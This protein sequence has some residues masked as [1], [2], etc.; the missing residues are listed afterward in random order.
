MKQF[1]CNRAFDK[2]E[3]KRLIYWFLTNYETSKTLQMID[4]LKTVGFH[5]ATK[6]GISLGIED[7]KIPPIKKRLLKNAEDEIQKNDYR[8]S[9]GKLTAVERS[10]K[11][12]DV[13]N[14]TS[15]LLKEE[16]IYHFRQTDLLNPVY[17][18]AFS[19]ARG[20][21]S[22][23]RQLVGMRGLMSDPQGEII[24]L[25]IKSNFREGLTVTEYI[26]SC[27]GARKGLVDTA[28]KTANSGYLTRRLVDVAQAVIINEVDCNAPSGIYLTSLLEKSKVLLPLEK[29]LVGRVLAQDIRNE[30]TG[31][32]IAKKNQDI[33]PQLAKRILK[34]GETKILVRS[35]LTCQTIRDLCKYC[36]GW[37]LAHGQL[38]D[39]GEAV[40]IIAAQSIGE[41]GTQ[42]TM[43]TFHT[44]GVFATDVAERVYAPH[45]GEI[46]YD[47]S[48]NPK[49]IR[50]VY[51]QEAIFFSD[52][53]RILLR[54]KTGKITALDFPP[55]TLIF[56]SSGKTIH[57]KQIIAEFSSLE[58]IQLKK[59]QNDGTL[60]T[61]EVFSDI[62]GQIFFHH[63]NTVG[64]KQIS[65]KKN[66]NELA[67][68]ERK[69]EK[70][71]RVKGDGLLW[72]LSGQ[73]FEFT[74]LNQPLAKRGDFLKDSNSTGMDTS[75]T[76]KNDLGSESL[77]SFQYLD[78]TKIFS[79]TFD[80]KQYSSVGSK[81]HKIFSTLTDINASIWQNYFSRLDL[82]HKTFQKYSQK[83][84][85]IERAASKSIS[86]ISKMNSIKSVVSFGFFT[87]AHSIH[88][89][90]DHYVPF[91]NYCFDD[92][93]YGLKTNKLKSFS[94]LPLWIY[95]PLG[96]TTKS[97]IKDIQKYFG[98]NFSIVS[99]YQT[100]FEDIVFND[101]VFL[102]WIFLSKKLQF[103]A[104]RKVITS[105]LLNDSE[106]KELVSPKYLIPGEIP[107][108]RISKSL[109]NQHFE[110]TKSQ[111]SI[112]KKGSLKG[113]Q[114]LDAVSTASQ[115][116]EVL[117]LNKEHQYLIKD[118]KDEFC[119]SLKGRKPIVQIDSFVFKGDLV[120]H[121]LKAPESGLVT[122]IEQNK[123]F[124][125]K[126]LP[127]R[128]SDL[129]QISVTNK[130]LVYEGKTLFQLVYKKSKTADI[131]QGL[132]KIEELLEARRTKDLQPIFNNPHDRL[133][134]QFEYYK[135][136]KGLNT[137]MAAKKSLLE[138]QQFLVN[139]VQ[140][141]Y[142]S[143][144]VDISD[145]HIEII[146][147][148]M[149]SKVFIEDG[150]Q[151]PL[152]YGDIVA[153]YHLKKINEEAATKNHK[154]AE[155]QPIILGITKASLKTESFL[156]AASFQE[157][158][159]VL[160]QAAIQGK[161]DNFRGLKE[162]VVVG[163]LIPAGT[164]F[165]K[166]KLANLFQR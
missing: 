9:R 58:Q 141:V 65:E 116:K 124:L 163:K 95:L 142:Q 53:K 48:G 84:N 35:P 102:E 154:L 156:S 79:N 33:C 29:R 99:P 17:M 13:W 160:T 148:Q 44:G 20:N 155:Y 73:I 72:V 16:V 104:F 63:I 138:I 140:L 25:P 41:P 57:N 78:Q 85:K 39:L 87:R 91:F 107:R 28:L 71:Y 145:K 5:Y 59:D 137:E 38:V 23:V 15:E 147:K 1:F 45:D 123:I 90:I 130:D 52:Q 81:K 64:Q 62:S 24:D 49:K 3:V 60:A 106:D 32:L 158:T 18:M 115:F 165:A 75:F 96:K 66:Q 82:K 144:G 7:L 19:G 47:M 157:T 11:V 111:S 80:Y 74:H 114:I 61:K 12:I 77:F 118:K 34:S 128:P 162:N 117:Y 26:I 50:T 97:S 126:V 37:S 150:G 86:T 98:L 146:V 143:Q 6:A 31:R 55:Y 110:F 36:Y 164:G 136:V 22:Q 149:T 131:V 152:L 139:G 92:Q 135:D 88:S 103:I 125:R 67:G 129:S 161:L 119:L 54:E 166:T 89:K 43:R 8:F 93:S 101:F 94:S 83:I 151:T 105:P 56:F 51:G 30:M 2:G 159:R 27:Y 120:A 113:N 112:Q 153:L 121:E 42:L 100:I 10:Q 40:G 133:K 69:V 127:Y 134:K 14:T 122:Q 46:F 21:I 70:T 132:P 4:R 76:S 108:F 109:G 68:F